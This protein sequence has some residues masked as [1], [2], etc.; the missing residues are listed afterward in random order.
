[1][2]QLVGPLIVVCPAQ[3]HGIPAI[4][5]RV[6]IIKV[7]FFASILPSFETLKGNGTP[8]CRE[9]DKKTHSKMNGSFELTDT[10]KSCTLLQGYTVFKQRQPD[11]LALEAL[12][13]VALRPILFG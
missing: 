9:A 2:V 12:R 4:N 6:M 7:S 13:F 5:N 11:Y 1:M 8:A 3:A 10:Q